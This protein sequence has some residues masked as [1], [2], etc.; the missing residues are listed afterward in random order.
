MA[1]EQALN[2][3]M[4]EA[5]G[6]LVK[7][8]EAV[9]PQVNLTQSEGALQ[10][11]HAEICSFVK[12]TFKMLSRFSETYIFGPHWT[13]IAIFLHFIIGYFPNKSVGLEQSACRE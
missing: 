10:Q 12:G 3:L 2:S 13:I 5:N 4:T 9:V 6:K 8:M 11:T 1:A 7:A